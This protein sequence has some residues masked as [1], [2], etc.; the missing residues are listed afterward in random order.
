MLYQKGDKIEFMTRV[1][2]GG[3]VGYVETGI[4]VRV[5]ERSVTVRLISGKLHSVVYGRIC[6]S[7]TQRLGTPHC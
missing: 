2:R 5:N 7:R 4:V 1:E 3:F 6:R